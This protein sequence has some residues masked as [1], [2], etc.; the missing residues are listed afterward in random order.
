MRVASRFRQARLG[1]ARSVPALLAARGRWAFVLSAAVLLAA[2]SLPAQQMVTETRD[3]AQ[4]QDEDF[5][6]SV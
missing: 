2:I 6:K 3:A 1:A 4:A 5:A